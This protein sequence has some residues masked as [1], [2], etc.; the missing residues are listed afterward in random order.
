MNSGQRLGESG[1]C[2][3]I[4]CPH[5]GIRYFAEDDLLSIWNGRPAPYG[6]YDLV[7][8]GLIVFYE[9]AGVPVGLELFD[10]AELLA[11]ALTQR[12]PGGRQITPEG[13]HIEYRPADDALWLGNG[14]AAFNPTDIIP[15]TLTVFANRENTAPVQVKLCRAAQQLG[16]L[17][18][19]RDS[20]PRPEFHQ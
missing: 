13:L 8:D 15:G 20:T 18:L 4:P 9:A 11:P 2:P 6:G 3:E 12:L 1:Q 14:Q 5:S 10:A 19:R 7:D 17:L 16:P